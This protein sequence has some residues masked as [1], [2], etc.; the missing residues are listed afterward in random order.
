MKP[1]TLGSRILSPDHP[2]YIIAEMS[3]NHGGSLNKAKE[4]VLA[5]KRAGADAIKLQTYRPDTITLHSNKQDFLLPSKNAWSDHGSLFD[6]YERAFTPWEWHAELFSLAKKIGID[7]FSTAFDETAVELLESLSTPAYKIASPEITHIP[8]IKVIAQTKK[9]V[10]M[11]TGVAELSDIALAVRTLKDNGCENIVILKCCSSY[12]AP[13]ET[14]HLN[15]IPNIAETFGC[16]AGYSDH[17]L[18]GAI[19]IAAAVLGAKVIEK[20]LVLTKK[21]ETIDSFFSSDEAEFTQIVNDIRS[22]EKALGQVSYE[23]DEESQKN[24]WGRRSIYISANIGIGDV[25][26]DKNLQVV[27][28]HFGLHPK[29]WADVIGRKC[30]MILEVGDRLTIEAVDWT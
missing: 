8:L 20:H 22:A 16:L 13:Y 24:Y 3:A 12:P 30:A 19:P 1:F 6:L 21:D 14:I 25:F 10:I 27:R 7:I 28:P 9:P 29:Y 26:T 17:T 5:A 18:G 23:L 11:S 4:I 15:T 2:C